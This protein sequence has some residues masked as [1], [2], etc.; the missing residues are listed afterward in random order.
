M[1]TGLPVTA[2]SMNYASVVLVGFMVLSMIY[3]VIWARKGM[4][5]YVDGGDPEVNDVV[6]N[7]T[8]LRSLMGCESIRLESNMRNMTIVR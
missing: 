1:P 6:Q 7:I 2:V 3:Y 8:D 4:S 5:F